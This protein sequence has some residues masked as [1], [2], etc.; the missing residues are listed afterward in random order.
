MGLGN[1]FQPGGAA[2]IR[3]D[4]FIIDPGCHAGCMVDRYHLIGQ[5][6]VD[7]LVI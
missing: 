7:V 3:G 5:E 2:A 1:A 6:Q 4:E